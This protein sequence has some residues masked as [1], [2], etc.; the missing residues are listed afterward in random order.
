MALPG[1]AGDERGSLEPYDAPD[2]EISDNR[3]SRDYLPL[4]RTE[5]SDIPRYH[6]RR[7]EWDSCCAATHP[8]LEEAGAKWTNIGIYI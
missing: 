8:I 7:H 3:S 4:G 6:P 1:G 5:L 2:I